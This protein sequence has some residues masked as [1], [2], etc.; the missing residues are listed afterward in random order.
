LLTDGG[1]NA[2]S[3]P[4]RQA[5]HLVSV[6]NP[7]LT[8]GTGVVSL[9]PTAGGFASFAFDYDGATGTFSIAADGAV[10]LTGS[11][12][13][14]FAQLPLGD[15]AVFA[16]DYATADTMGAVSNPAHV[17]VTIHPNQPPVAY[18]NSYETDADTVALSVAGGGYFFGDVLADAGPDIDSDP[19][20][21]LFLVASVTN[22]TL[23]ISGNDVALTR[24]DAVAPRIA[25]GPA[26]AYAFDYAGKTGTFVIS[27]GGPVFLN[28]SSSDLLSD[29]P[30]GQ[31]VVFE[32]DYAAMDFGNAVSNFAHVTVTIHG[33]H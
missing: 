1:P 24:I 30:V 21:H 28:G 18:P 27:S 7:T 8:I 20:G 19:E 17:T 16:F 25:V 29:V 14:L 23:T 13:D 10:R 4:E 33:T 5:I 9:T 22:S 3:D 2:D 12:V 15:D 11:S 6:T 32:F 31:D 26:A